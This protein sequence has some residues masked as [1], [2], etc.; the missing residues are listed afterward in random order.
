MWVSQ[1]ESTESQEA[2]PQ[3]CYSCS[4]QA[5]QTITEKAIAHLYAERT[6][7]PIYTLSE[8][9]GLNPQHSKPKCLQATDK[10][11]NNGVFPHIPC[12]SIRLY[13]T[14]HH[15]VIDYYIYTLEHIL[16]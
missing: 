4:I 6:A 8:I 9:P 3:I 14:P 2:I 1:K 10:L 13:N 12:N 15:H 7:M 11:G 16:I 5:E